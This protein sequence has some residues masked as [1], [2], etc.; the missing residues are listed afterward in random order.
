MEVFR[1]I[2]GV[3]FLNNYILPS[4]LHAK[5]I[6]C[7]KPSDASFWH[8]CEIGTSKQSCFQNCR[9]PQIPSSSFSIKLTLGYLPILRTEILNYRIQINV[10]CNMNA[11]LALYHQT[12]V[13]LRPSDIIWICRLW[14]VTGYVVLLPLLLFLIESSID[15]QGCPLPLALWQPRKALIHS[16]NVPD[17]F[18][19]SITHFK[20]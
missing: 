5:L 19:I 8:G 1:V 3:I 17:E 7:W 9:D 20:S 4:S 10:S 2:T 13:P 15:Y 16:N 11:Q 14:A 18:M 12:D 6:L